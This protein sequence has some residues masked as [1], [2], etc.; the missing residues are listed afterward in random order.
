[1]FTSFKAEKEKVAI[2]GLVTVRLISKANEISIKKKKRKEKEAKLS[3]NR[4]G[5]A[6]NKKSPNRLRLNHPSSQAV[7]KP[8]LSGT[9][10]PEIERKVEKT[11]AGACGHIKASVRRL[12]G[13]YPFFLNSI[14]F[15][16]IPDPVHLPRRVRRGNTDR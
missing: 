10:F 3:R 5:I 9:Q 14:R 7:R 2:R 4:N 13:V 6:K 1:M 15:D 11:C 8:F 12:G 16:S